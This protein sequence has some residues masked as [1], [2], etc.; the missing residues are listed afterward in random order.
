LIIHRITSPRTQTQKA[1]HFPGCLYHFLG[2]YPQALKT[3]AI[4]HPARTRLRC[5]KLA[6]SAEPFHAWPQVAAANYLIIVIPAQPPAT[7]TLDNEALT[8]SASLSLHDD[9]S[10][11]SR[12]SSAPPL[13]IHSAIK[14]VFTSVDTFMFSYPLLPWNRPLFDCIMKKEICQFGLSRPNIKMIT[15]PTN[16]DRP[17]LTEPNEQRKRQAEYSL[18]L[19]V[20]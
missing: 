9:P 14:A 11:P 19:C 4:R 10:Q 13:E 7:C 5:A 18:P 15:A 12:E 6:Q 3:E 8:M 1:A 17:H 2:L 20:T 16:I